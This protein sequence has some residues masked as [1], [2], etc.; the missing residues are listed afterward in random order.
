MYGILDSGSTLEKL[1]ARPLFLLQEL[2]C[3]V[4]DLCI[5]GALA[6]LDWQGSASG[7]VPPTAGYLVFQ[8]GRWLTHGD[9][10]LEAQVDFLAVVEHR[11]IPARV[12]GEWARLGRKGLAAI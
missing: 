6:S 11:L 3:F 2:F 9:I 4:G 5:A 1:Q 7:S 10:V 8:F 12:R